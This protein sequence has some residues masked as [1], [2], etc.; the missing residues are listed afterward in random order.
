[1]R[2]AATVA[3]A[4]TAIAGTAIAWLVATN[5]GFYHADELD[6]LHITAGGP[7]WDWAW[8]TDAH[9]LFYRPL[10]YAW[11]AAQLRAAGGDPATTHTLSVLH[12][13][14]NTA[15]LALV[16][17]RIGVPRRTVILAFL[18]TAVPAVAW[19][20]AAYDRL[21][22]TWCCVAALLLLA[23]R[24]LGLLALPAFGLALVAK[25]ASIAF[26]VPA[27]LLAWHSRRRDGARWPITAAI[28]IAIL[29]ITFAAWRIS[30]PVSGTEYSPTLDGVAIRLARFA[31]F[32]VAPGAV[33]PAAVWGWQWAGGLLGVALVAVACIGSWR[34]ALAG[35]LCAAAPMAP[36]A[37]LPKVEGH[38]LYLTT[39]G[40]LL[41][42]AAAL[43]CREPLARTAAIAVLAVGI[44]HSL[45]VATFYRTFGAAFDDLRRA[46]HDAG[47]GAFVVH[48]EPWL[49]EAVVDRLVLHT[50]RWSMAPAVET[51]TDPASAQWIVTNDGI[52]RRAR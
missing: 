49:G 39:P 48:G 7:W 21:A 6:V 44:A 3:W 19:A 24:P 47:P 29:A 11:L 42:C 46:H 15:L 52:V 36:I 4:G 30:L 8:F 51:T 28:A 23:R 10:G 1:M 5:R 35:L 17:A 34:L 43:R 31:A 27:A 33:D 38:Y 50:R 37:I 25:E 32:P 40:L 13:L 45:S 18:P 12:H 14:G 22:L 2:H 16:F 20:A 41:I 26:A 9:S